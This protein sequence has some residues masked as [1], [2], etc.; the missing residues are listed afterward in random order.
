[1]TTY[2]DTK[3]KVYKIGDIEYPIRE[4]VTGGEMKEVRDMQ[5]QAIKQESAGESLN[6]IENM[7]FEEKWYD[8][9][10]KVAFG[11]TYDELIQDLSEPDARQ[12]LGEAYIFLTKFGTIERLNRYEG[13][14]TEVEEKSKQLAGKTPN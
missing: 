7:T 4:N 13:V 8:A 2:L 9:V 14:L 11:K 12:L 5:K 6:E 10:G 1:M 3:K